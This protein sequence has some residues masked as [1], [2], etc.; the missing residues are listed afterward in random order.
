[1]KKLIAAAIAIGL[2]FMATPALANHKQ[3]TEGIIHIY[4]GIPALAKVSLCKTEESALSVLDA[5]RDKSFEESVEIYN[6]LTLTG[7]CWTSPQP[8]FVV[9]EKEIDFFVGKNGGPTATV[10]RV[11]NRNGENEAYL[12]GVNIVIVPSEKRVSN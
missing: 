11:Q 9:P 4:E 3:G 1:M 2:S 10:V 12:L 8:I 7:D 6:L 5:Y